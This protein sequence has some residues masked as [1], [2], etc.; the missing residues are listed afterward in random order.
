M[1][2]AAVEHQVF[3][4]Y[5]SNFLNAEQVMWYWRITTSP[6]GCI[7]CW[8]IRVSSPSVSGHRRTVLTRSDAQ[9]V[10]ALSPWYRGQITIRSQ[11]STVAFEVSPPRGLSSRWLGS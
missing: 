11:Q 1:S 7:G 5:Q 3:S 6:R 8:D 9:K 4:M 2:D 10:A